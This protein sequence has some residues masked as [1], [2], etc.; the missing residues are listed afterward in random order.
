MGAYK[1]I[2]FDGGGVRG[3]FTTQVLKRM[4]DAYGLDLDGVDMFAG[5]STGSVI[6]A[7]LAMG[8]SV[9]DVA[10]FYTEENCKR[11]FSDRRFFGYL[12]GP[13]YRNGPLHAFL[14]ERYPGNP[15]LSE[16]KHAVSLSSFKLDSP[17]TR[18]WLTVFFN[19]QQKPSREWLPE[20]HY[21]DLR[22]VDAV[23]RSSA[24]PA[25]FPSY[26]GYIDG[27][28]V[29][30]N[31]GVAAL[32]VATGTDLGQQRIEDIR[33]VSLGNGFTPRHVKGD[34][35]WGLFK[36]LSPLSGSPLID[37]LFEGVA[38]ADHYYC[39]HLL[40]KRYKR[41]NVKLSKAVVLDDYKE[42]PYMVEI[43]NS[44]NPVFEKELEE[45]AALLAES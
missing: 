24:A 37:I 19:N 10:D 36:W 40:G 35:K 32:A 3:A 30:N 2:T 27:G 25:Y 18:D 23:M 15:K 11:I 14:T 38:D 34:P 41:I 6:A 16:L 7:G 44:T 17:Y 29:A 26:Q 45:A 4:V 1:I 28:V 39:M 8:L 43:A 33:L 22:L 5:T 31:P 21:A 42:V 12:F 9:D 13:K 20:F